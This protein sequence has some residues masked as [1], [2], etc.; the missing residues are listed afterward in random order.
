[1]L[2]LSLMRWSSSRIPNVWDKVLKSLSQFS[3]RAKLPLIVNG[4]L[5]VGIRSL[6]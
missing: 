6:R 3:E 1:M 2:V 5:F 4:P